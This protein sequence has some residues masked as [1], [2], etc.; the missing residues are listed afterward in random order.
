MTTPWLR[1]LRAELTKAFVRSCDRLTLRKAESTQSATAT[2]KDTAEALCP[3]TV[4]GGKRLCIDI[5]YYETFN[6]DDVTLIDLN[7]TPIDEITRGGLIAGGKPYALDAI[8]FAIG[9][10]AMTGALTRI[11]I[12]GR[13]GRSLAEKWVQRSRSIQ[14]T[15]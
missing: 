15:M 6:R 1:L 11:D 9:F 13:T 4:V 2:R 14:M 7:K 3:R 8:V 5:G 10:D 12:R